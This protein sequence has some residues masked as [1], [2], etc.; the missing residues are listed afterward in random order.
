M[1]TPLSQDDIALAAEVALGLLTPAEQAQAA[2]RM[3]TDRAFADEVAAWEERFQPM[4]DGADEIP[5]ERLWSAIDARIAPETGQDNRGRLRLWQ[6]LTAL[7]TG[8]AAVLAFLMLGQQPAVTP[9][10]APLIAA[11]GSESGASAMTASY[12][13]RTGELILTPVA[14]DTGKLYPELWVVP[15][16]GT[17]RSLGIVRRDAPSRHLVPQE[18]RAAMAA[19]ATLAITP[20][21][22]G[23]APGGKATGPIIASGKIVRI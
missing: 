4:T 19:G 7:S 9:P 18:L 3:A 22:E 8:V 12:D 20:E 2:A 23:G 1:T 10:A 5:P 6:G 11:L 14:L 16:G 21:P 15:E 13:A 17:A